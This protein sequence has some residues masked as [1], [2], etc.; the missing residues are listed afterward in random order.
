MFFY[1]LQPVETNW[2]TFR[3]KAIRSSKAP[4]YF[5]PEGE[6]IQPGSRLKGR[7]DGDRKAAGSVLSST[8]FFLAIALPSKGGG[9]LSIHQGKLVKVVIP[10]DGRQ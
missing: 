1:G 2:V 7:D 6:A 10:F 8:H 9:R 5:R 4:C 3:C